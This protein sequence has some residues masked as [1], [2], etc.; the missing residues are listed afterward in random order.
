MTRKRNENLL[1]WALS[2][3]TFAGIGFAAGL[4]AL[5]WLLYSVIAI[6]WVTLFMN[7]IDSSHRDGMFWVV[8]AGPPVVVGIILKIIE[9]VILTI[10]QTASNS[11]NQK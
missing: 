7:S 4:R 6:L 1:A 8:L 3:V 10:V 2:I 9:G 11:N 5:V